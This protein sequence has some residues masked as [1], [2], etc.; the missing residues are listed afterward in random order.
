MREV[1]TSEVMPVQSR[2]LKYEP[3]DEQSKKESTTGLW[4]PRLFVCLQ[5]LLFPERASSTEPSHSNEQTR[6]RYI[7]FLNWNPWFVWAQLLF[8]CLLVKG[9]MLEFYKFM[10][11]INFR[12]LA[13]TAGWFHISPPGDSCSEGSSF[14]L[15][16]KKFFIIE[17]G[18]QKNWICWE[19]SAF[20]PLIYS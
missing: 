19:L 16:T 18:H 3:T 20:V 10:N 7:P 1:L 15:I 2:C 5:W 8:F 14:Y 12:F 4:T 17:Q 13:E 9:T 11:F 6:P